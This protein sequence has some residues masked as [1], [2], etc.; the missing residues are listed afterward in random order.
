MTSF[1]FFLGLILDPNLSVKQSDPYRPVALVTAEMPWKGSF[2]ARMNDV[3]RAA[4]RNFLLFLEIND[5][6][7]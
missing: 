3:G 2:P 7:S 4:E 6:C 1:L 5:N